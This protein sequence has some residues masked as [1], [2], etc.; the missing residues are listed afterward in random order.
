MRAREKNAAHTCTH[1]HTDLFIPDYQ[2]I[3]KQH[4]T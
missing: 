4:A 1:M 2:M 3:T